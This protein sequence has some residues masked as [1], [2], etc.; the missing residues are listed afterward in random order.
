MVLFKLNS[1]SQNAE[2]SAGLEWRLVNGNRI[3]VLRI[4]VVILIILRILKLI[5][6]TSPF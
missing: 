3:L 1:L 6:P 5:S 2:L 4:A